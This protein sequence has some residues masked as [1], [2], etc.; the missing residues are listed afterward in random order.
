MH[1]P[2]FRSEI[3]ILQEFYWLYFTSQLIS[4][5]RLKIPDKL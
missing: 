1:W 4:A 3:V 2:M 5:L